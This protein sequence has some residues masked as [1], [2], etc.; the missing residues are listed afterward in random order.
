MRGASVAQGRIEGRDRIFAFIIFVFIAVMRDR[1]QGDGGHVAAEFAAQALAELL[2]GEVALDFAAD[3][4]ADGAGFFGTDDGDGVGFFGDADAG[5]MARAELSGEQ[6]I[7]GKRKKTGG[8]GDAIIFH[9][10]GAVVQ[11]GAGTENCGQQIVGE[12]GVEGH[13]AFDVGAQSDFAFDHDECA[14]LVLGEKIRGQDDVVVG[15]AVGG[16]AAQKA[17]AAAQVGEH[18]P[19]L[20]LEDHDQRKHQVGENVADH[21]VQ[22]GEFADAREIES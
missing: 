11:R 20:R 16:R 14:G 4:E 3:G 19:D 12:A 15:I 8:G 7:H 13:A 5:A 1:G 21:P 6:R 22:R 10:D 18:V 17:Q 9:D 2:D